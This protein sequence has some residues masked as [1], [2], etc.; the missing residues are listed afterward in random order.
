M[1]AARTTW[2]L[3]ATV[4]AAGL[5]DKTCA[6]HVELRDD[7][8]YCRDAAALGVYRAKVSGQCDRSWQ[9]VVT[10]L[11]VRFQYF[12]E[13]SAH[14]TKDA[15]SENCPFCCDEARWGQYVDFC[16]RR[17]VKPLR[18]DADVMATGAVSVS[19]YDLRSETCSQRGRTLQRAEQPLDLKPEPKPS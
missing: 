19:I 8:P 6:D 15:D 3:L 7:C 18:R 9:E 5:H 17:G 12:E 11:A 16:V 1:M 13:C 4:F 2:K 10:I 14:G